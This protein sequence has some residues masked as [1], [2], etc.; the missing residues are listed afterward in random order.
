MRLIFDLCE[1]EKYTFEV[2]LSQLRAVM[3]TALLGFYL[4]AGLGPRRIAI[5]QLL[6]LL[7]LSRRNCR[8]WL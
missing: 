6:E 1:W 5:V 3:N 8:I 7:A 2:L 4:Q